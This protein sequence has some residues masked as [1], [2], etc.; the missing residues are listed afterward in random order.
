MGYPAEKRTMDTEAYRALELE[1]G[2]KH[3]FINGEAYAMAGGTSE[4]AVLQ[5]NLAVALGTR[6]R[7]SPCR[8]TGSDQKVSVP[9]TGS[10]LY[11]DVSVVC[12]GFEHHPED[13]NA[14]TNPRVILEVLS[15]S[16]A[17]YDRGTKFE[18]YR[19]IPS[20]AEY[21][22][23]SQETRQIEVRRRVENGWLMQTV[24]EG[25][26]R[27]DALGLSIPLD[28]IY[29][30]EGVRPEQE[31]LRGV[32]RRARGVS[33]LPGSAALGQEVAM[34]YPAEKRTMDT[35]AYR[36]L[37][38]E[39][40]LKHEFINGEAYAMAGG[41]SEHA[42]LQM[43]LAVALGTRLR[44][45]PCRPTGSDQK[46]SVPATGSYLYADVSV[47]CGGFEHHPEDPNAITNPRV[48]LE[49]LSESTADY[50]RGTKFE[51]YRRI[52][53]LAEYVLVSQETRQIEVRRRVENGWLMQT[54]TEGE[55][56]LDALGLSIPLD[57]I[58]DL[59]GVRPEQDK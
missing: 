18:H 58:Y 7:G 30:L 51:H 9:A 37:E 24:T 19:R 6:L 35:E 32:H 21:V 33:S 14:I 40:G 29:D 45:S 1:T 16:T 50:D 25:E 4:H 26:L 56:R 59:E 12:G 15:E 5:M 36:A 22:L 23:V 47:V 49:V 17:D 57:E 3:E 8:P 20:L 28:E 44:G 43:N 52:P 27:L 54:V 46:V 41:T 53:S 2:L 10:Y 13:P 42:V 31:T 48:I 55:L 38:L 11:A 34:G 39:T